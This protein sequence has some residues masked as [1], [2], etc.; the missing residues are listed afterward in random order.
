MDRL[1]EVEP[2][3]RRRGVGTEIFGSASEWA[4]EDG[5]KAIQLAVL[6]HDP[7]ARRFWQRQGFELLRRRS[8]ESDAEKKAHT[9]LILRRA[10]NRAEPAA[11]A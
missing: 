11:T 10:I 7:A 6:E 2:K 3:A 5:A 8:H 1:A 4:A 9:V